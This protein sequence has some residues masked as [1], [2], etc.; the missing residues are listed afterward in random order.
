MPTPIGAPAILFDE[1]HGQGLWFSAPPTVDRGFSQAAA[2]AS[3]RWRVAF[4]PA[5]SRFSP[6]AL[7]GY[8][9]L[10]L[11]MGPEGKTR[12]AEDEIEAIHDFVR[13]GGGL[14]VLGAYTGDWHH[15]ANLS[16]LIEGYGITF[17]R[18]VILPAGADVDDAF[19]ASGNLARAMRCVV[20][21]LPNTAA[22]RLGALVEQV[23]V[24]AALSCCSLYVDEGMAASI[25]RARADSLIVEPEPVGA[26]IHILGYVDRGRG[27][28]IL[29][30]ASATAKV[31]VVGSWRPFL[32]AFLADQRFSN[33]QFFANVLDHLLAGA[34]SSPA[35]P[36][37]VLPAPAPGPSPAPSLGAVEDRLRNRR[38]LL[39][40]LENQVVLATGLERATLNVHIEQ[41]K[42]AIAGDEA[43]LEELHRRS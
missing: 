9:A 39:S 32:D 2:L 21:A 37:A 12:L 4:A 34:P 3:Q 36:A 6:A 1:G 8:A 16:R 24:V 18:D 11:A 31:V 41:V 26:G 13:T 15:E 42:Q 35:R 22:G 38:S 28:A 40:Q 27:P 10:V 14:L 33:R 29:A 7:A 19:V 17:N 30:A 43:E 23:N 25:L 20:E 5:G